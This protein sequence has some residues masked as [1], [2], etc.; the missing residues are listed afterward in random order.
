ME[1]MN[2]R[3]AVLTVSDS[4]YMDNALDKSGPSVCRQLLLSL[5][6]TKD[7][8][9]VDCI[10]AIVP[11][12]VQLIR[13]Q[14]GEWLDLKPPVDVI[15]T[16]GGTGFTPRDQTP[17]AV[18]EFI[19]RPAA[20]IEIALMTASL[21]H[22]PFAALSRPCAGITKNNAL[23]VTMPGSVKACTEYLHVLIPL[24]P[25]AVAL[26]RNINTKSHPNDAKSEEPSQK[27][28]HQPQCACCA[29]DHLNVSVRARQSPFEM[30]SVDDALQM[31][32]DS[33]QTLPPTLMAL[34]NPMITGSVMSQDIRAPVNVPQCPV[35]FVDGYAVVSSDGQGVFPV[36]GSVI[37][38]TEN[39]E[40]TLKKGTLMRI[41]TG[42]P[43]PRCAD[44]VVMVED[45]LLIESSAD[46]IEELRVQVLKAM[47]PG[48]FIRAAGSDIKKDELLFTK[49]TV[50]SG[51]GSE[52]AVLTSVGINEVHVYTK[53]TVALIS[54]GNEIKDISYSENRKLEHAVWD[55]NKPALKSALSGLCTIID[56]GIAR[57]NFDCLTQLFE[58]AFNR[59]PCVDVV[60]STGGVSMGEKDYVKSVLKSFGADIKFG[61]VNMKPGKPTTFAVTQRPGVAHSTLCFGLAGNPVSALVCASLFVVPALRKLSGHSSYD[62]PKIKVHLAHA[63]KL[64]K[65][66]PE[67][68]RAS[69]NVVMSDVGTVKFVATSTGAQQSS[70]VGSMAKA[71]VLLKLPAGLEPLPQGTIV[72]AMIIDHSFWSNSQ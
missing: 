59:I 27:I 6:S 17:E 38:D 68:H 29:D 30:T 65:V 53:P 61:R 43:I 39:S 3:V 42:A 33:A 12:E 57:D 9:E 28:K 18:R 19:E 10:T 15:L 41:T 72:D 20:G 58:C 22:T 1:K 60:I 47:H 16:T 11:D 71:H 67:F 64:D 51:S 54:T 45:T 5:L 8:F 69:L 35:S 37:S 31:V 13:L 46:G 50:I 4:A 66:R 70:R 62:L 26:L 36:T 14:V 34:N 7:L 40:R 63:F 25:H 49:G 55:C 48:D 2:I 52:I 32:M 23:I 56:Y 21:A 44:A 24:L